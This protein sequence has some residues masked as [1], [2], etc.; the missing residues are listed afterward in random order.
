LISAERI[1][2]L[3]RGHSIGAAVMEKDYA[4]TWLL[5]GFGESSQLKDNLVLKGGTS[6]RK[7][8]FPNIWR[9]SEDLDFSTVGDI[10]KKANDGLEAA[11]R[12]LTTES[13]LQ[14]SLDSYHQNPGAII[15]TVKFRG[16][17]GHTN[18]IKLDISLSEKLAL[19]P[20]W[21]S[22][23]SEFQDIGK[24]KVYVYSLEEIAAEKIRSIMQ[25][26]YS[27]DYYDVWRL[28]KEHKLDDSGLKNLVI[29]KCEMNS[30]EY[31]PSLLFD[32]ARLANTKA[33]WGVG[34]GH[35]VNELPEFDTT[36]S[37]LKQM[38]SFMV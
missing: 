9:F 6:I 1:R 21:I 18:K 38:L 30:I 4:L 20:K 37:D 8:Y 13:G 34:L 35:L 11:L 27:R 33:H 22:I 7:V 28:G 2:V 17:L 32:T 10:G 25:R 24:L 31:R 15:S 12:H 5:K 3:A 16:P 36:I 14:Y 23:E 19:E 29:R 26:G